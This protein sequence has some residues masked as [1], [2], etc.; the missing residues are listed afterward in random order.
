MA[1]T[2]DTVIDDV[3]HK[4]HGGSVIDPPETRLDELSIE[5]TAADIDG[6]ISEG[7]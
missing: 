1:S 3:I 5:K 6:S 4:V 7:L 2:E